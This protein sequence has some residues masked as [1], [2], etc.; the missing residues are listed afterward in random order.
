MAQT[1]SWM[2]TPKYRMT[3]APNVFGGGGREIEN[4][5]N[6]AEWVGKLAIMKIM[7]WHV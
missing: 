3:P 7:N 1:Q 5:E 6:K 2:D 4:R